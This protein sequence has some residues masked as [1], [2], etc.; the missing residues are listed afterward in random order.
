MATTEGS[1]DWL[2]ALELFERGDPAFVE[3]VRLVDDADALGAFAA[4]WL[5]DTRPEARQFLFAYLDLPL[6]AYRHEALVKRL[7]KKAEAA[8]DDELMA[9][10]LVTFDRCTRRVQR[11]RNQYE[12]MLF[13]SETEANRVAEAW[14]DQGAVSANVW[15]NWQ[16]KFQAWGRWEGQ[17]LVT[18]RQSTMPR[19]TMKTAYDAGSWDQKTRTYKTFEVPDWVFAL[20]LIPMQFRGGGPLPQQA[21]KKLLHR[22]L[23]SIATRDYLRR[24][25]WRYFRKLGR[26]R[27]EDYVAAISRALVLYRDEDVKDG[28]ALI[29]NWG[30]MHALFAFSSCLERNDR[31]WRVAAG[32]SLAELAPAPRFAAL[33]QRSPRVLVD[34][35]IQ[36][37]CRPVR[38]W[39][40]GMV[41][42][43]LA[44]V[45]PVFPL[46]ER[47]GLL[48]HDD[49]EVVSLVADLLHD[50]PG[51][52]DV[53][54][55]QWLRLLETANP[56]TLE[57]L[58]ELIQKFIDPASVPLG[59]MIRLAMARP[60]PLAQLGLGWLRTRT[61]FDEEGC[62][63]LLGLAEAEC[64]AVRPEIIRWASSVL[65]KSDQFRSE[66][67]LEWLDARHRDVRDVAWQWFQGEPR[68]REDV[69]L[70]QRLM[71]T[72]YD[73]VR[74]ALIGEL[75][76]RTRGGD[77]I[78][79]ERG[80]LDPEL[81]RFLWAATLLN[82]FRG[83]RTK[84]VVV[85]Q[86]LRRIEARPTELPQLLPVL[87]VALRSLRGPEWRSGLAAVV[88]LAERDEEARATIQRT[89]PELQFI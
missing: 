71:E 56:A 72:P 85:R 10:F 11:R 29:D 67:V 46:E 87:A 41:R 35:L 53:T 61:W 80:D 31:A 83:H 1:G 7:F 57:L 9:H 81:V 38:S 60:I 21:R 42:R 5:A 76:A 2:L 69:R 59:D 68:C 39:A 6:N 30:L 28:L 12:S 4:R 27:P 55:A 73:E 43:D 23:F 20:K 15:R 86:L 52:A 79:I 17:A 77:T 74:H 64:E 34:L 50:D 37:R 22:R 24:R 44:A 65:S 49:T 45:L 63:A 3:Q 54:V 78:R 19:G 51:L 88:Q 70:W 8:G 58:R 18:P 82:V 66:W 62:R 14:R 13:D 40:V 25:A 75:E 26:K 33:W 36:A 84:P 47:L 16:G 48:V 32:R 89:L